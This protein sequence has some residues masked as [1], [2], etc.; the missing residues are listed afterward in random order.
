MAAPV[1][2]RTSRP[3]RRLLFALGSLLTRAMIAWGGA[4]ALD[5][6]SIE[7]DHVV[8]RY[9]GVR[10][11]DLRHAHGEVEL[12]RARGR[13][14]AVTV[15]SRRGFLSGHDRSAALDGGT[16]RLRGSCDFL[17]LGTC[18]ED[19]RVEV[20]RGVSV[21]VRT[22]A[23]EATA[24]GLRGDLDLR[25]SAGPVRAVDVRGRAVELRSSA[26]PVSATGVVAATLRLR[27]SAGP[28]SADRTR[29]SRVIAQASAGP[30][31]LELLRPPLSVS[32]TSTAGGVTVRVPDDGYSVD[33]HT[34]AGEERVEVRQN[35]GA[36]RKIRVDS[37]AGDVNVLPL[38]RT[39]APARSREPDRAPA[40]RARSRR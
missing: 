5:Q 36:R 39:S 9:A 38:E 35:P 24:R 37:S 29:A 6:L 4:Q 19:Y 16:L 1:D 10:V 17:T 31:D 28:V 15:D 34:S 30:V 23:G 18:E 12:V 14:V 25:S 11:I 7:E 32:A 21:T 33:A 26:G 27:S 8:E 40:A 22:S 3:V 20:P 13:Q 2:Y